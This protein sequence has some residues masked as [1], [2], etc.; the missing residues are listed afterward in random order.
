MLGLLNLPKIGRRLARVDRHLLQTL[1]VRIGA[2]SLSDAVAECK[3]A[4]SKRKGQGSM[5]DL[6]RKGVED[7]RLAQATTWAERLGIDPDFAAAVLYGA[8]SESCRTQ[9]DFLHRHSK[10]QESEAEDDPEMAWRF[11]REQLIR[12]TKAVAPDY[13]KGYAKQFFGTKVYLR[14]EKGELGRLITDLEDHQLALDLGCATGA[15]SVMLSKHF[16]RVVGYDISEDMI[17]EAKA[18]LEKENGNAERIT[19]EVADLE[20]GIPQDDA[21]VSLVLMNLGTGSDIRNIDKLLDETERVLCP[22]GAFLFSFYNENSLLAK[23][24]F[25]PWPTS[26]AAMIDPDKRCLEVHS[27]KDVFLIYARPYTV[28]E[29]KQ[30]FADSGLMIQEIFTHP[31]LSAILPEDILTTETFKSYG[32]LTED[33]RYHQAVMEVEDNQPARDALAKVD[34]EL[35]RSPHNLGAYILVTGVKEK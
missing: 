10:D 24:G 23:L 18:R 14:F 6:T 20:E 3:L 32:D 29:V 7:Q 19:F 33:R 34:E 12:L 28:E 5:P 31:S 1:A 17:K 27:G 26:L 4:E 15:K 11:Y 8:I 9:M 16:E 13:D 25:L 30:L 21:S 22:G 2:G 35:A